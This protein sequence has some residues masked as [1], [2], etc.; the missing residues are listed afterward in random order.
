MAI[1]FIPV[2]EINDPLTIALGISG[3]SGTGKTF[4][5]LRVAREL[6]AVDRKPGLS[7]IWAQTKCLSR[8]ANRSTT[9]S[10]GSFE[11]HKEELPCRF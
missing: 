2:S 3:G 1:R 10:A 5:S 6:A 9:S 8:P 4:T 11:Q 7:M